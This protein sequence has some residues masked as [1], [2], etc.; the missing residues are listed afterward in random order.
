MQLKYNIYSSVKPGDL[1]GRKGEQVKT[2]S[3]HGNVMIV[4]GTEHSRF[5]VH[6]DLLTEDEV[7][8][9]KEVVIKKP[10]VF[11]HKTVRI[12]EIK[13]PIKQNTLF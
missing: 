10:V 1:Y 4:E 13:S 8:V 3:S 2:I 11:R 12:G 5:A 6:V 7:K 9:D